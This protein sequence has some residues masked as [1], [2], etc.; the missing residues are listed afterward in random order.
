MKKG[1]SHL[2][3]PPWPAKSLPEVIGGGTETSRA[4]IRGY[5]FVSIFRACA[6][7]LASENPSCLAAMQRAD[8][9]IDELLE[10]L[11]RIFHRLRQNGL[12]EELFHVVSGFKGLTAK[13]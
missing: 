5:F 9:N 12:D 6:E 10:H 11:N 13:G 2:A 4:F 7:S 8:K 1:W 3:A